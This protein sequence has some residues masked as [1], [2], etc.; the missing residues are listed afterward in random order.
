MGPSIASSGNDSAAMPR[1]RPSPA[2]RF[3]ATYTS[4][5]KPI[6]R[7][8]PVAHSPLTRG[9]ILM[10]VCPQGRGSASAHDRASQ[11]R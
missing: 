2:A 10:D 1:S 7:S 8:I 9:T 5:V 3:W 11:T 4:G 6:S